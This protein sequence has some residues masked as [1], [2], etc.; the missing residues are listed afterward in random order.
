[1]NRVVPLKEAVINGEINEDRYVSYVNIL[2]S[3]EEKNY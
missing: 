1:M 3:I 2:E